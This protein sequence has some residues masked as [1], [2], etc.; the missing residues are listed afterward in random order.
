MKNI[1]FCTALFFCC[2]TFAQ[3]GD[4]LI[5]TNGDTLWGNIKIKDKFFYVKGV[6]SAVVNAADVNKIKSKDYKGNIVFSGNLLQYV[7]NII[8]LE[9][10]YT[11][12]SDVDT[13]LLIEEI[14]STPK[15]N[16][17]YGINKYKT[18][19][20]FYKTPT[21]IK[22]VQLVIRYHLE[23]GLSNYYSDKGKY[24]WD[25]SRISIIEDKGYVNQLYAIMRD[26]KTI[27]QTMWDLLSYRNYSLKQ[28]IKKYNEC[29]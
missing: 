14:Y 5:K 22:P 3:R 28:V 7:D 21:D 1:F 9:L 16:L 13:V 4:H 19:F 27:P 24:R 29:N 15:I 2:N 6:K 20:Y 11:L 10:D 23:G 25:K 18:P 12:K 17:Y 26:C 8:D